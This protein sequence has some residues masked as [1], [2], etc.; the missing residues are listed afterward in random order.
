MQVPDKPIRGPEIVAEGQVLSLEVEDSY[1]PSE[2]VLFQQSWQTT[3][4]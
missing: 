3:Q 2:S 1:L 4:V